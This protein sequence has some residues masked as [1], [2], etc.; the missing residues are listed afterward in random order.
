MSVKNKQC[1]WWVGFEVAVPV[2]EGSVG[3]DIRWYAR[4]R[5]VYKPSN[6]GTGNQCVDLVRGDFVSSRSFFI[7]RD[8]R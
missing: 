4:A 2:F 1:S 6:P 5:S 3:K 7:K 8:K